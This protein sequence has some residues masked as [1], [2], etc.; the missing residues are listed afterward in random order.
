MTTY[1]LHT[2]FMERLIFLLEEII[3]NSGRNQFI[4]KDGSNTNSRKKFNIRRQVS[5]RIYKINYYEFE[6]Y[7]GG[8]V[9]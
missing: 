4:S 1:V 7:I 6:K 9:N 8:G 5:I 3:V 2:V